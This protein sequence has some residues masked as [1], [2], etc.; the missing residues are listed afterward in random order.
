MNKKTLLDNFLNEF[1]CYTPDLKKIIE[2]N[3]FPDKYSDEEMRLFKLKSF[4]KAMRYF[5]INY[6][7]G[8]KTLREFAELVPFSH[9]YLNK[10]ENN[11]IKSLQ[12]SKLETIAKDFFS[13]V[14]YLIGLTDDAHLVPSRID[15]YFWENPKS[16]YMPIRTEIQEALPN[17]KQLHHGIQVI[18]ELSLEELK[19]RICKSIGTDRELA[20]T[21]NSLLSS[22]GKKR[23][24][25]IKILS[26][27]KN[28]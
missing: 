27:L 1:P 7:T 10:I 9:T 25:I 8:E 17:E 14:P 3:Q 6:P 5:R 23:Y 12:V 21:L 24:N 13:S 20:E 16:K 18:P 11:Q 4:G 26:Y 15:Y 19:E 22:S 28:F 2:V